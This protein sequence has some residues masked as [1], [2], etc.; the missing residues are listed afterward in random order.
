MASPRVDIRVFEPNT[1]GHDLYIGDIHGGSE[2]LSA[3]LMQIEPHDRVFS[4]GDLP[5]RG[6]DSAGVFRLIARSK[7]VYVGEGN[8][9]ET[10]VKTVGALASLAGQIHT[11]PSKDEDIIAFMQRKS[12]EE[13]MRGEYGVFSRINLQIRNGGLWLVKLFRK[14]M[15]EGKIKV[16]A[17]GE[18]T[19]TKDS[20]IVKITEQIFEMP[21]ISYVKGDITK[22]LM[23]MSMVHAGMPFSDEELQRRIAAG[24]LELTED[25]KKYALFAREKT[26]EYKFDG[27]AT[28]NVG[29]SALSMLNVIGHTTLTSNGV[30]AVRH[31]TATINTDVEAHKV[32]AL[33]VIN[34]TKGTCYF[35]G[36]K[37]KEA[38]RIPALAKAKRDIEQRLAI[39]QGVKVFLQ[40][41]ISCKTPDE[42]FATIKKWSRMIPRF[43][44]NPYVP[45]Q[46]FYTA[47]EFLKCARDHQAVSPQ[48][49]EQTHALI[50][51]N[52]DP[53]DQMTKILKDLD[54]I[55][56][57]QRDVKKIAAGSVFSPDIT[58]AACALKIVIANNGDMNSL[59]KHILTLS[60]E[61]LKNVFDRYMVV[62]EQ[63]SAAVE[64]PGMKHQS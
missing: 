34:A 15:N 1:K 10:S 29:R 64:T 38:E 48:V 24:K 25:E 60:K 12:T 16:D 55:L 44:S 36:P 3:L 33:L 43:E 52:P 47:E 8:H 40:D 57:A 41:A 2:N 61:P 23:P 35:V 28:T 49:F 9:E 42:L 53:I 45:G 62:R 19:N 22:G 17:N 39:Q 31:E 21:V 11:W 7:N 6:K 54:D 63:L 26:P 58:A 5:D 20:E 18:L 56:L 13:K 50:I 46:Q 32:G 30:R 27:A 4:V 51:K 37:A 14:E 59:E